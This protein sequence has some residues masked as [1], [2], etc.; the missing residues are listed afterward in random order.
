MEINLIT[1]KNFPINLKFKG[2][3]SISIKEI[4][5]LIE[6]EYG[7]DKNKIKIIKSEIDNNKEIE[8]DDNYNIDKD[9][10][11][12]LIIKNIKFIEISYKLMKEEEIPNN[13]FSQ[14]GKNF[15]E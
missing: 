14:G 3:N 6:E 1:E 13:N 9:N 4:K 7:Y 15:A 2:K 8:L 10:N 5:S 11:Q 12:L